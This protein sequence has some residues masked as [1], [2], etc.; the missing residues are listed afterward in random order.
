VKKVYLIVVTVFLILAFLVGCVSF[1]KK[2]TKQYEYMCI[3]TS[4]KA[5]MSRGR[6]A[7]AETGVLAD[8]QSALAQAWLIGAKTH[9]ITRFNELG[10]DGYR[11]AGI[12]MLDPSFDSIWVCFERVKQAD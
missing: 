8:S 11:Y 12:G 10:I 6:S 3:P 2:E 4:S 9:L 1:L 7:L 5:S